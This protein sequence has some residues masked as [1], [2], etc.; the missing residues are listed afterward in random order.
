MAGVEHHLIFGKS[1]SK[2]M[3]SLVETE[4]YWSSGLPSIKHKTLLVFF[5]LLHFQRWINSA[6]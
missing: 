2:D 4:E 5:L 3:G 6:G 1:P